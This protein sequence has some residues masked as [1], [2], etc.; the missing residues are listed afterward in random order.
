VNRGFPAEALQARIARWWEVQDFLTME[1]DLLDRRQYDEWLKCLH[2][3][4]VY[5][6]PIAR[7]MRRDRMQ[8]EYTAEGEIAWLDEGLPTLAKRVAQ[9]KT[10]MHWAEEPASRVSRI[11]GNVRVLDGDP[12]AEDARVDSRFVVYQN[13]LDTEVSLFAGQRRDVLR[14]G[15]DGWL[16]LRRE[17]HL[18]QSVLLTK[19]LT[20]FF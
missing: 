2:P 16:L 3:E 18:S 14:R 17:V 7:N 9:L 12:E 19:A 10:G 13:R 8:G 1:A 5:R 20:V 15:D 4:L 6:V 11:V